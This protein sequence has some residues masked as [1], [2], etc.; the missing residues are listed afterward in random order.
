VPLVTRERHR[1][2]LVEAREEMALFVE[3]WA[4]G[5]LP[6]PVAAVHL[7]SAAHALEELIG[8]VDVEEVLG[9]VFSTF[10]IGK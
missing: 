2:G 6:A 7:R 1:R 5:A 8:A 9:R 4:A 10:C 3:A